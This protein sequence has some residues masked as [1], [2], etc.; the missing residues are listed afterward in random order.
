M[1][2]TSLSPS[3]KVFV[4]A[5][6]I[7]IG[8]VIAMIHAQ[9][10]VASLASLPNEVVDKNLIAA[11][12]PDSA[13]SGNSDVGIE[14]KP[15]LQVALSELKQSSM[16]PAL[17]AGNAKY[18][19]AYPQPTLIP[20]NEKINMATNFSATT[21]T[22]PKPLANNTNDNNDLT[23][24]WNNTPTTD[25]QPKQ[26]PAATPDIFDMDKN[27]NNS[28]KT[29]MPTP[30]I[31]SQTEVADSML[32]FFQFSE[33]IKSEN[34]K[35]N[36][37]PDSLPTN[38]FQNTHEPIQETVKFTNINFESPQQNNSSMVTLKPQANVLVPLTQT[39]N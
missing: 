34:N 7:F 5:T 1:E 26:I 12:L 29:T 20:A 18:T 9:I 32:P 30:K 8:S 11:P 10:P 38:P 31:T 6:V 17:A 16:E 15:E 19:Q 25:F 3:S 21:I 33:N 23:Q 35:S 13:A 39:K 37:Q 14:L 27:D 28:R 36:N 4:A 22:E 2:M 24:N